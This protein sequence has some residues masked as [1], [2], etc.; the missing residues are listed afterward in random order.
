MLRTLLVI[1]MLSLSACDEM[2][3][4]SIAS[5]CE[6]DTSYCSDL[7]PD[8]WCRAEKSVI[9]RERY[10]DA[11]QPADMN[12]YQLLLGFE[13]YKKCIERASKIEHIKFKE[14]QA[15]RVKGLL[16]AEREIRRLSN[17]TARSNDPYLL[18][19]HW[20]RNGNEKALEEFMGYM[21]S[22]ELET[23][24]LQVALASY[25][26]KFDLPKTVKTLHH[27]IELHEKDDQIDANIFSSLTT[28]HLK[29]EQ[30][31]QAYIWGL[32]A[33]EHDVQDLDIVQVETLLLQQGANIK[34]LQK[35][36]KS[37]SEAIDKGQFVR[38]I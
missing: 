18:Y 31:D 17:A 10:E 8:S 32:V 9:I 2:S 26:T 22:G 3:S 28:I 15:G 34:Q 36:A 4:M 16:T 24:E 33:V 23:S 30:F 14:K 1:T 13:A 19:Y 11:M 25:Y 5:I 38:P 27:A 21:D 12:K 29:L 37:Y 35:M 7:N 20:S 6:K